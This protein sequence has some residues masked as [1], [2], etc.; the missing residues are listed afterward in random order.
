MPAVDLVVGGVAVSGLIVGMVTVARLVGLPSRLAPVAAVV[1]GLAAGYVAHTA[2]TVPDLL[3]GL[4]IGL[5][6]GLSAVGI[7]STASQLPPSPAPG[8]HERP[9]D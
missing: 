1:F 8:R 6:L 3:T 7:H 2:G 5:Q 4:V 9:P